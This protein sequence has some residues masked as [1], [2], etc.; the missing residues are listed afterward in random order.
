MSFK[1][2][3]N[4][5]TAVPKSSRAHVGLAF[6]RT[7]PGS[8]SLQLLV[9]L[10]VI[11]P[12]LG[13]LAWVFSAYFLLLF[14]LYYL[15]PLQFK[16]AAL[17]QYDFL[18]IFVGS[19]CILLGAHFIRQKPY[20]RK[21]SGWTFSTLGFF[22]SCGTVNGHRSPAVVGRGSVRPSH[23]ILQE[24][25]LL[26]CALG[27]ILDLSEVLKDLSHSLS[28]ICRPSFLDHALYLIFA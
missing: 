4:G 14:R 17:C 26:N 23:N 22:W 21:S 25:V 18:K 8:N 5:A 3:G 13:K 19:P 28:F 11:L 10:W 2:G 6:T 24:F 1:K 27:S 15:W 16:C 9:L 20:S 7:Q 12:L